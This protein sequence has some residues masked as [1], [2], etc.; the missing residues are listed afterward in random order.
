MPFRSATT[1][2]IQASSITV[3]TPAGTVA[4][5]TLIALVGGASV[6]TPTGWTYITDRLLFTGYGQI[7]IRA[8][9]RIAGSSEPTSHTFTRSS[10]TRLYATLA[11]YSGIYSPYVLAHATDID[12]DNSNPTAAPSVEL[13]RPGELLTA[14]HGQNGAGFHEAE[15]TAPTGMSRRANAT[16]SWT[17]SSGIN[18]VEALALMDQMVPSG[19]TVIRNSNLVWTHGDV[20]GRRLALTLVLA[21]NTAP[22]APGLLVPATNEALDLNSVNRFAWQHSDPDNDIQTAYELRYRI[23]GAPA[24]TT[25][26]ASTPNGFRDFPAGTFTAG[27][28]EWQVRT[29]DHALVGPWSSSSFFSATVRTA[30][31]SITAPINNETIA[32]ANYVATWTGSATATHYQWRRVADN[33]GTPND[34]TVYQ[35][36]GEVVLGNV[37]NAQLTLDVNSR[38]EHFQVREKDNLLWTEWASRRYLVSFTPPAVPQVSVRPVKTI[39]IPGDFTDAIAVTLANP[40]P[41]NGQPTVSYLNLRR[42]AAFEPDPGIRIGA[43]LPAGVYTDRTPAS[44]VEYV[45][46][47][48]AVAPNGTSTLGPWVGDE[49]IIGPGGEGRFQD[50]RFDPARFD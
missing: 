24:W 45:Y 42:K 28:Y 3:A 6:S 49:R 30:A 5:D 40:T 47:A 29:Y 18:V 46:A 7:A 22:H 17:H 33:L 26:S 35:D 14:Y 36:S 50:A 9:Y 37:R 1:A 48:E 38:Y 10:G 8:M 41:T 20:G 21:N 32:G 16:G 4:G 44:G 15:W 23:A 43:L 2:S 13:A 19:P 31:P 12:G 39:R 34:T 27:S 25:V 11:R